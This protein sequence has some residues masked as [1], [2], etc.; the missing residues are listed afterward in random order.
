MET[1]TVKEFTFYSQALAEELKIYIY[2]PASYTPMMKYPVMIAADG[3]DYIQLGRVSRIMNELIE[4]GDIDEVIFVAIPY[5]SVQD[6]RDK[7]LPSGVKHEAYLTFLAD[8]L[9][10]YLEAHYSTED[11][12]EARTLLGDSQA[13][14]VSLLAALRH[15]EKFH[16]VIMHSPYVNEEVMEIVRGVHNVEDYTIYHAIGK[17]ETE[18]HTTDH[19][20]KD[21][22]TPNRELHALMVARDFKTY[23]AE[24][25]GGHTWKTWQPDLRRAFIKNFLL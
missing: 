18:V 13:A 22:L 16:H 15:P 25:D 20:I 17:Q 2:L 8:E 9:L 7:Y 19:K 12:P 5:K 21:F 24:L 3:K 11:A 1:G 10:P 6:R 14:T 4:E 23:Y